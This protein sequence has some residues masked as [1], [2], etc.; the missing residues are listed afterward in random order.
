MWQDTK[1]LIKGIPAPQIEVHCWHGVNVPTIE[2]LIYR[3][4]FPPTSSFVHPTI[5][6]GDGDGTVT[7]RSM[8]ACLRWREQQS[9]PVHYRTFDSMSH[10]DIITHKDLVLEVVNILREINGW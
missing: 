7:L 1:D 4:D 2:Q 6:T 5:K 3:G 8:Q 10:E 9:K